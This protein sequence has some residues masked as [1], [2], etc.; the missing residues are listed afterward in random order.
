MKHL[1]LPYKSLCQ[2][3]CTTCC[4][5]QALASPSASSAS[6]G[7]RRQH[8]FLECVLLPLLDE[9]SDG[10]ITRDAEMVALQLRAEEWAALHQQPQPQDVL[11]LL[12]A[13]HN[14]F[15]RSLL[16]EHTGRLHGEEVRAVTAALGMQDVI[17]SYKV[18]KLGL[19]WSP[20]C[21]AAF[22]RIGDPVQI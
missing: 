1:E 6:A 9:D 8:I 4:S 14:S 12:D 17:R 18:R 21:R 15:D 5:M 11:S 3:A 19:F 10:L 20:A 16:Q 22:E 7:D 2:P 13:V